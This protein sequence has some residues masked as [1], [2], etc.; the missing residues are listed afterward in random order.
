MKTDTEPSGLAG[1]LL[2]IPIG[3]VTGIFR[4]SKA[5]LTTLNGLTSDDAWTALMTP[6]TYHPLLVP[7]LLF[8]IVASALFAVA[9][10]ALLYL[11]L[12]KSQHFPRMFVVY[13]SLSVAYVLIYRAVGGFVPAAAEVLNTRAGW[14]ELVVAATAAAVWIPYILR[15]RRVKNT[16]RVADNG[17]APTIH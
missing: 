6:P 2:L 15:S 7:L 14:V 12:R 4:M 3:L 1:W 17:V 8:Q 11:Y 16:F 9:S 10:I 5:V 13:L